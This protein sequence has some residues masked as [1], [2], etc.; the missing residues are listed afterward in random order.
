MRI[1]S[2]A[3]LL[4]ALLVALDSRATTI[5]AASLDEVVEKSDHIFRAQVISK[6]SYRVPQNGQIRTRFYLKVSEVI[7]GDL[8]TVP[9]SLSFAGGSIGDERYEVVGL[10]MPK[11]GEESVFFVTDYGDANYASPLTAWSSGHYLIRN[12]E[13]APATQQVPPDHARSA[14][15]ENLSIGYNLFKER[16]RKVIDGPVLKRVGDD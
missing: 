1:M 6:Q 10:R 2:F 3:L 11:V 9:A 16:I 8:E 7:A 14:T 4:C 5:R 13:V 15:S 12:E